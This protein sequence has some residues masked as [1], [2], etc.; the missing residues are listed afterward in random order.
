MRPAGAASHLDL[1]R[2]LTDLTHP[3]TASSIVRDAQANG[4]ISIREWAKLVLPF[5]VRRRIIV[6]FGAY[7]DES[8][9]HRGAKVIL[10]A[11]YLS[12]D[13]QWEVFQPTWRSVLTDAFEGKLPD[14]EVPVF[15]TIDYA[16]GRGVFRH[17]TRD[18]RVRLIVQLIGA[19]K[20]AVTPRT[21]LAG[22]VAVVKADH[23]AE[24]PWRR[25]FGPYAFCVIQCLQHVALWADRLS[26]HED[27]AYVFEGGTAYEDQVIQAMKYIERHPDLVRKFRLGSWAFGSKQKFPQLQAADLQAWEVQRYLHGTHFAAQ[28]KPPRESFKALMGICPHFGA[29]YDRAKLKAY[30]ADF[31]QWWER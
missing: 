24:A 29:L 6:T 28:K 27:V 26:H 20:K 8:G 2:V 1:F 4:Y 21:S 14:A 5:D 30:A 31:P 18:E 10:A 17:L 16:H 19:L 15:H 7:V 12:T 25:H 23:Q 3:A 11:L 13:R 22:S 9:T